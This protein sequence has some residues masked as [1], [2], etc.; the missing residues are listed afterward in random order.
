MTPPTPYPTLSGHV[1]RLIIR[2]KTK[3]G[4]N[5]VC[6]HQKITNN[7][8]NSFHGAQIIFHLFLGAKA[9]LHL[10]K[11][12]DSFIKKYEIC[13]RYSLLQSYIVWYSQIQSDTVTYSQI[14]SDILTFRW[15]L[16]FIVIYIRYSQTHSDMEKHSQI[17]S[18]SHT[19]KDI[20]TR[21]NMI[22]SSIG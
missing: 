3:K 13:I 10:A 18:N 9:P 8:Q 12:I 1:H 5:L 2:N 6:W 20:I 15:I 14:Q 17:Q 11:F 16:S 22:Q 4:H 19:L 21:Q 7:I